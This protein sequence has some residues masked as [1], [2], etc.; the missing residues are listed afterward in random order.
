[1]II[2]KPGAK[3]PP[4]RYINGAFRVQHFCTFFFLF[5]RHE[6]SQIGERLLSILPSDW[7]GKYFEYPLQIIVFSVTFSQRVFNSVNMTTALAK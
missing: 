3:N 6:Y 2:F 7:S 4:L 5:Y 1:M